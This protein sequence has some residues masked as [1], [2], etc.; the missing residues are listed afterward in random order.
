MSQL[1]YGYSN[2]YVLQNGISFGRTRYSQI[3]GSHLRRV[4]VICLVKFCQNTFIV[5]FWKWIFTEEIQKIINRLLPGM[6]HYH[7]FKG[8]LSEDWRWVF[9]NIFRS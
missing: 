5:L 3:P 2:L 8:W 7:T 9:S 4:Y 1:K 6:K